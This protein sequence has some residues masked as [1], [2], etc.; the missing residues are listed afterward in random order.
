MRIDEDFDR[1]FE[2]EY[3]D[4]HPNGEFVVC[5]KP[6]GTLIEA[7]LIWNLPA[8]EQYSRCGESATEGVL[9]RFFV[10]MLGLQGEAMAQKR[11]LWYGFSRGD[12]K[13]FGE[14][15]RRIRGW[16]FDRIIPCHGDVVETG[17]KGVF[18]RVMEW[19]LKAEK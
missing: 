5:Y 19:H 18:E 12:R 3:V 2:Y 14:S 11:L 13:G 7:D 1:D 15:M 10:G 8:G 6:E 9:T 16:D 4:A 17:G